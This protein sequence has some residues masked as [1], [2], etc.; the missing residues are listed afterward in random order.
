MNPDKANQEQIEGQNQIA[1]R[2]Y[3]TMCSIVLMAY[4]RCICSYTTIANMVAG[5]EKFLMATPL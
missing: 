4:S 3:T 2:F 5:L 1:S